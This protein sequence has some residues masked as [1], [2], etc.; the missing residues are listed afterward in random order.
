MADDLV[1]KM[2]AQMTPEEKAKAEA[3]L[4]NM[5]SS[6]SLATPSDSVTKTSTPTTPDPT[7]TSDITS[8]ADKLNAKK[9]SKSIDDA[10]SGFTGST[11]AKPGQ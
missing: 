9:R 2:R 7:G 6:A 8:L 3:R 4:Q 11:L 10:V 1:E 5:R